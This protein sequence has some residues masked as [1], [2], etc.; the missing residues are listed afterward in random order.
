[1]NISYIQ[2][3]KKGENLQSRIPYPAKLSIRTEQEI[4]SFPDEHKLKE[5]T[6]TKP[7]LQEMLETS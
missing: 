1:M 3:A 4:K 5:F 6:T 2:N 7:D